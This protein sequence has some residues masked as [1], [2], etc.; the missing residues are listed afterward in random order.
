M[1]ILV[2]FLGIIGFFQFVISVTLLDKVRNAILVTFAMACVP[3]VYHFFALKTNFNVITGQ[4]GNLGF[5]SGMVALEIAVM[6]LTTYFSA[7]I[8]HSHFSNKITFKRFF[9]LIPPVF[10]IIGI[11]L[12]QLWIFNEVSGYSYLGLTSAISMFLFI[13]VFGLAMLAKLMLRD[14][15]LRLELKILLSILLIMGAM[16]LPVFFQNVTI[17]ELN[18]ATINID[19]SITI[20]GVVII[21]TITGYVNYKLGV[22]KTI[23]NRFIKFS[24]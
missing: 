24:T 18:T 9:A 15:N 13:I 23:W 6:F 20:I 2:V 17:I 22:T 16:L 8:I 21:F 10:F 11:I 4:L 5:I 14:W 12:G 7:D 3:F 1:W 19:E